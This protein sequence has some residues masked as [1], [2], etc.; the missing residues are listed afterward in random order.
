MS[1]EPADNTDRNDG[2][3][4]QR[5]EPADAPTTEEPRSPSS[6]ADHKPPVGER[7]RPA[8]EK[9][10]PR[11][12]EDADRLS[13][14]DLRGKSRSS[15]VPN[16]VGDDDDGDETGPVDEQRRSKQAG[17]RTID[18]AR[19]SAIAQGD[20][21]AYYV[22]KQEITYSGRRVFVHKQFW[23]DREY[24]EREARTYVPV[25]GCADMKS[26]LQDRG[27]VILRGVPG[28][29]RNATARVL[30][31][32]SGCRQI[33]VLSV[34]EEALFFALAEKL[35]ESAGT[36]EPLMADGD[37]YVVER[38]GRAMPDTV[39]EGF[40]AAVKKSGALVVVVDDTESSSS[41]PG[42]EMPH[43]WPL[44]RAKVLAKHLEAFL[45]DHPHSC[46]Q[47]CTED[48]VEKYR[49]KILGNQVVQG[50]LRLA[51]SIL[52]IVEM[53]R[54]L[55]K[56]ID[57]EKDRGVARIVGDWDDEATV[58]AREVLRGNAPRDKPHLIPHQQAFRIAYAVFHGQ[59]LAYAF[60]AA[61]LLLQ[62][63]ISFEVREDPL[64]N[65]IFDGSVQD[66][67]HERM[68]DSRIHH[69][70]RPRC[71]W[72][73]DESLLVAVL[74]VA[75]HDYDQ[76]R[77]PLA[78][79]LDLLAGSPVASVQIR[80][81]QIAGL[82]GTF[83]YAG[84]FLLLVQRWARGKAVFRTS[85][86]YAMDQSY[87]H[88]PS[89]AD[90][91]KQIAAWSR[92]NR[93]MEQDTAARW[94]GLRVE[95]DE[96]TKAIEAL[97][98]LGSRPQLRQSTSIAVA[99]SLLFLNDHV[100]DVVDELG[101]W[102]GSENPYLPHHAVKALLILADH[103]GTGARSW[104]RLSELAERHADRQAALVKMWQKALAS[105]TVGS[106]SWNAMGK[107]LTGADDDEQLAELMESL[108][109]RIFTDQL[110]RRA[111]FNLTL[112]QKRHPDARLIR[113]LHRQLSHAKG[114]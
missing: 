91:R 15:D 26:D 32:E 93:V 109:L 13:V 56:H 84:V 43:P 18:R 37:G 58:L 112:W 40:A 89:S 44:D 87:R 96:V 92:S 61:D 23:E 53:A 72:L 2:E 8:D 79:W 62:K 97:H 17:D 35:E 104:P 16:A 110:T 73:A 6:S 29:G 1:D 55:A 14:G 67:V 76:L 25:E 83:D 22:E 75:W 88:E 105:R 3:P 77:V 95:K 45:R 52:R 66:L 113:H 63:L 9:P 98:D 74:E 69:E 51:R 103:S 33:G 85:A 68:I 4:A 70:E 47:G 114:S 64:E 49:A 59:P 39:M 42:F 54:Y 108:A 24:I 111:Q 107:W 5:P 81:A 100:D 48:L 34:N 86:A 50:R 10:S 57:Q 20:G 7:S 28:T 12:A 41:A 80:A 65:R 46:S 38:A 11:P 94:Y 90:V 30:L 36:G 106:R 102:V 82:L 101:R 60:S 27:L 99:M 31:H 21:P 78:E 19:R 71:A